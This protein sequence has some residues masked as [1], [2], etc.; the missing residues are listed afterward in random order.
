M[1][2]TLRYFGEFAIFFAFMAFFRLLGLDAASATGGFIGRHIFR[3]LPPAKTA[4]DNLRAAFPEMNTDERETIVA[5]VCENLGRVVA[6]Y[7]FLDRFT[8]GPG[9]RIEIEGMERAELA[10][11]QGKGV[12]FISAHLANWEI[13]PIGA[14]Y[15]GYEG[16]IVYRPPNNPFVDRFIARQRAT[17]GPEEQIT[18]G[19]QGTRRIFTLLRRG[20]SIFMLAD[21]KTYEGV[22]APFFGRD[23]LTTPAPASLA[24]KLGSALVPVSCIR[25]GGANFRV[26]IRPPISFEPSG[27]FDED[28]LALTRKMNETIEAVVREHPSQWL[29]IHRRWTTPRDIEKMRAQG[30]DV[31]GLGASG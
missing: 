29:W 11:A 14:R 17:L 25:T 13:M 10:I 2:K 31:A 3:R 30:L 8:V 15:L 24:L 7:A 23:A 5:H 19:A 16:A 18:K 6:E 4:R 26:Q 22:P 27:N 28:V 20:K 12:M 1:S 21:Q 9:T